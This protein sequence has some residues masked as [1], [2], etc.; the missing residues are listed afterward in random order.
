MSH[1]PGHQVGHQ[2]AVDAPANTDSVVVDGGP[3]EETTLTTDDFTSII[4]DQSGF[5]QQM[6]NCQQMEVILTPI[7][8]IHFTKFIK[9]STGPAPKRSKTCEDTM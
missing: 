6:E 9:A 2:I 4:D 8:V 7:I 1:Q 5:L 3:M